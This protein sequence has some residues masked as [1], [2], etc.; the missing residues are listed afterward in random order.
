MELAR[1]YADLSYIVQDRPP[2]LAQ[3]KELW[4]QG[5]PEVFENR[6]NL[7]PHDF[8]QTNPVKDAAVYFLRYIL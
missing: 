3:G 4:Q 1:K 8:F 2:V 6:V 5:L 7:M